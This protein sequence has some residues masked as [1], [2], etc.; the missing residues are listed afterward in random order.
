MDIS[1]SPRAT[2]RI[3][4]IRS[5]KKITDDTF[6]RIS[7]Q[8]GGCSGLTYNLDFDYNGKTEKNDRVFEVEGVKVVIDMRSYL[9]LAGTELDYSEGFNGKGFHFHNPNAV[10]TCSCGESF[11]I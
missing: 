9:Y 8:S 4:R 10:R 2:D 3:Q 5:E 6:L 1:I 11:S 7:V